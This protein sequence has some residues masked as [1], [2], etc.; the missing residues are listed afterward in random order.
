MKLNIKENIGLSEMA[1][2]AL[3][4]ELYE[5]THINSGFKSIFQ[6]ATERDFKISIAYH[7]DK[8]GKPHSLLIFK[9]YSKGEGLGHTTVNY[10]H[11]EYTFGCV[12]NIG[13]YVSPELRGRGFARDLFCTIKKCVFEEIKNGQFKDIDFL[14]VSASGVSKRLAKKYIGVN[15]TLSTY[16]KN[17]WQREAK[18]MVNMGFKGTKLSVI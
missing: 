7:S 11:K 6:N 3:K 14:F 8:N 4:N 2:W 5:K 18:I 1:D 17:A 9:H 16:N 10:V 13:C 15:T 12:G